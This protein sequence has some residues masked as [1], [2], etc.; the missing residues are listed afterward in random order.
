[1]EEPK[2]KVRAR[3][4]VTTNVMDGSKELGDQI[5]RLMATLARVEQG[6]NPTRA[7]NSPRHKGHGRGQTERNTPT[8]PSSHNGWIG[9]GQATSACG[10]SAVCQV[11]TASQ[12]R[13]NTQGPNGSHSNA[14]NMK[15]TNSLQCF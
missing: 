10:Y 14:Q 13:G 8:C 7:S 1:M 12:G 2:D 3:S 6:N 9:L 11:G 4:A 5:A 15:D